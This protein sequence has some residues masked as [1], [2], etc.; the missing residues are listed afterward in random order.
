MQ[1]HICLSRLLFQFFDHIEAK[2]TPQP[3]GF[4]HIFADFSRGD[5]NAA[6][7]LQTRPLNYQSCNRTTNGPKP[8]LND[9]NAFFH[10]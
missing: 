8:V 6:D 2:G 5:I 9:S 1:N 10:G 4:T 7:Q 3:N